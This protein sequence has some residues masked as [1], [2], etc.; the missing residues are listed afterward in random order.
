M[1]L[2]LALVAAGVG[3]FGWRRLL[4]L[5][6]RQ[7]E[8][9]PDARRP[10]AGLPARRGR[11]SG[12]HGSLVAARIR[13]VPA[14]MRSGDASREAGLTVVAATVAVILAALVIWSLI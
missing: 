12:G 2:L 7:T 3:L 9:A 10:S 11:G 8:S 6:R 4:D 13:L 14:A 1:L 5:R